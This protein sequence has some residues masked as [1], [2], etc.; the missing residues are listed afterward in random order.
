MLDLTKKSAQT[1]NIWSFVN[2]LTNHLKIFFLNQIARMLVH[3]AGK[4][5]SLALPVNI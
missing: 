3:R 5:L 1:N 4:N 2:R